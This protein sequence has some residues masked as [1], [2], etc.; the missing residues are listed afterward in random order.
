[1]NPD[2][3][4]AGDAVAAR[5]PGP[6]DMTLEQR[7][8]LRDRRPGA[9]EA[10]FET[11]FDPLYQYIWRMVGRSHL[12]E[13]LTQDVFMQIHKALDRYDPQRSLKPWVYTIATN[14]VRDFWRSRRNQQSSQEEELD[15]SLGRERLQDD[16]P[17]PAHVMDSKE[18]GTTVGEAIEALPET[19]RTTFVLR[20]HEGLSFGEIAKM[21]DRNEVA[22]RKRYSRALEELRQGLAHL[23][24]MGQGFIVEG[25]E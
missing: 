12:A 2:I 15:D 11:F 14:R 23:D 17:G 25:A 5:K 7:T 21:V 18:M 20:F 9:M 3:D 10:F 19:L 6:L 16:R 1:M 8:A 24:P 4:P 22:V 13:D